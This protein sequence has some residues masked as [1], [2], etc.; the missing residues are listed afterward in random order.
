MKFVALLA[1]VILLTVGLVAYST[2]PNIHHIPVQTFQDIA[3]DRHVQ[4]SSY[5]SAQTPENITIVPGK[6]NSLLVNATVALDTGSLSSVQFKIFTRD[7]FQSCMMDSQPTGCLYNRPVS[8]G[9]I[10]IPL[11]QT[12]IYYFGFDNT[13][14]NSSKTVTLSASV[15]TTSVNTLVTK[16]GSWNLTGLGLSAIGLVVLLYGAV[17]RTIIPWE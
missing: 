13:A 16:D 3:Q 5:S 7:K 14:S 6:I 15:E 11:N 12:A 2:I 10:S 1:G 9:T 8:N 4:V 17:S